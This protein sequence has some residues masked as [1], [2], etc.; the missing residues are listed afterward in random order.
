MN[1]TVQPVYKGAEATNLPPAKKRRWLPLV[2]LL[3]TLAVGLGLITWLLWRVNINELQ[4][5]LTH[6]QYPLLALGIVGNLLTPFLRSERFRQLYHIDGK[7]REVTG[8]LGQYGL[9][10]ML[11]PLRAGDV[12]MLG[13]LKFRRVIPT[14]AE[15]LPRWI[16]LRVGDLAAVLTIFLVTAVFVPFHSDLDTWM[17]AARIGAASLIVIGVIALV[18]MKTL[19]PGTETSPDG[20]LAGRIWALRRGLTGLHHTST[21]LTMFGWSFVIWSWHAALLAIEYAAFGLPL[22]PQQLWAVSVA[23][24]AIS[25]LPI[26]AP[27][28]IGTLHALQVGLLQLFDIPLSAAMATAIGI[29]AAMVITVVLQGLLGTLLLTK[30]ELQPA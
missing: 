21:L 10:N 2:R 12:A 14:I 8:I 16:V 22:E 3:F 9:L 15:A 11:L 19:P 25:I 6:V 20:F 26:H 24:L 23:I 28:A 18:W 5:A 7:R 13:V 30:A 17:W 1:P 27:L 4:Q 29:H